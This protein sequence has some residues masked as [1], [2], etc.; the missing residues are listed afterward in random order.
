[1]GNHETVKSWHLVLK[2]GIRNTEIFR[3]LLNDQD[4]ETRSLIHV[5]AQSN[6]RNVLGQLIKT[7][8]LTKMGTRWGLEHAYNSI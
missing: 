4:I 7:Q 8:E 5:F 2:I 1:M 3:Q 6:E